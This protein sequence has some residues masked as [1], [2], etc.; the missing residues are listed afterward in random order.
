MRR[1]LALAVAL[2]LAA[3]LV[4]KTTRTDADQ[5][6]QAWEQHQ[7]LQQSSLFGGLQWRSIGP[8]VQGGR[9]VDIEVHPSQPYTFYVAYAS[10]GVWKTVNNGVSFTPLSDQ[11]PTMVVGDIAIDPQAPDTL[12]VGSGE[13]NSSR[14]S[15]SGLGMFVSRDGGQHFEHAGL[16]GADRIARVLVDPADSQRVFVAVQGPLY[17]AGGMRG[18]YRSA[19]GGQSWQQVLA[20]DGEWTGAIDLIA[21]P[22][23]A[24]TLYAAMWERSR[25]P[26]DFVEGGSGSG[27][28]KST[29][30]GDSWTRLSGFPS[31][32]NIGRIG[33]AISAA[34]PDRVY[35]SI[36]N[37]DPLAADQIDMGDRPLSSARLRS[38]GKDEFLRQD[39][40]EIEMFIRGNDFD[41][42]VDAKTL[43]AKIKSDE[44]SMDQLRAKLRDGNAALFDTDIKSLEVWRSD[45]AGGSWA[46]ANQEPIR[47]FTYTYGYYFGTIKVAPD[48][49]DRVY[50][51]GLPT[52][53]SEDAGKTWSG[54]INA[55]QVHVDHH[56]W[57][58]D[59]KQPQRILNGN[60]GGVDVSY[61]GGASWLKLD[62]QAVGQS[63]S[64]AVDMEEPYN[65]YTGL[66]DNGS[67]KGSSTIDLSAPG[68]FWDEGGD[69]WSF[70]NGGD[71]MQVQ[72]DPRDSSVHYSGFQFGW[73]RRGGKDGGEV[74]PRPGLSDAAL[75]Y[76]WNTPILLSEHNP[77]IVYFGANKLFRS[78]DRG[79][80]WRAI[81][82][83]LTRSKQRGN[84]PF[85][86]ITTVSESSREFG[87]IAAGTDDGLIWVTEDGGG[88]W[89]EATRG[90][91]KDRWVSRV[92]TSAHQRN[93]LYASLNGYRDDDM[94]AYAYVSEDLGKNWRSISANLPAEPINV[95]KE[96][97][98]NADVLYVGSDRGVYVSIDR[99][100]SWQALQAG[101]P[102]VPVHDLVVHPRDRELVAGTH[103]RSIWI[104]DVLPLQDL[105]AAVGAEGA[106]LFHVDDVSYSRGWRGAPE[107][108]FDH[109]EAKPKSVIQYWAAQAG[110]GTL[111]VLDADKNPVRELAVEAKHGINRLEYDL[112]V[113]PALGLAAEV[114]RV[115]K[116]NK[117]ADATSSTEGALAKT[118]LAESQR[119]GHRLYLTPGE[120]TLA[121]D[122]GG[123]T[124]E[125]S[126]SVKPPKAFE[127]R[128]KP[129]FKLRGK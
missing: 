64:V 37:Q 2:A 43:I 68:G 87:L 114:A 30:G 110:S 81:S 16:T 33:L 126:L 55:S 129:K 90:L 111:K 18:I 13:A 80:H 57:T 97:P 84:V 74:R 26:W 44:I 34:N 96:D 106:H 52:A 63:Y 31:G 49:A 12:W 23:D 73:Y 42:S 71:G 32:A 127:S 78:L 125:T 103:G 115:N 112:L 89:R 65:V 88:E 104:V 121:L 120:Y 1:T 72:V 10:G 108:W 51:L 6:W 8:T 19:D 53:I 14:S 21:D 77:D 3:P 38:M 83:D 70:I 58:I 79:R 36:D 47:D 93:R 128:E 20:G 98:V 9:V 46:K 69:G 101:L 91:A 59:P 11:M 119:L 66:Q 116:A 75:R 41:P 99:G 17:T 94:S 62:H 100:G 45:D 24:H 22:R 50:V 56:A 60:D 117:D 113:D 105:T 86:T 54:R 7:Q 67:W 5:R 40:D 15:Y 27:V 82:G 118:P 85:A 39:P 109:N 102:N 95:I 28:Y 35:A 76:N 29:D 107:R 123:A 61:D 48:N 122:L 25:R 4:A 92:S 124:A